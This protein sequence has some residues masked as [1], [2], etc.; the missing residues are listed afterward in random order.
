M[1]DIIIFAII[2]LLLAHRLY[3]VLGTTEEST[4]KKKSAEIIDLDKSQ[5]EET[6]KEQE[7]DSINDL[8][9][10]IISE[11]SKESQ[12]SINEIKELDESFSIY[13]FSKGA[14]KAFEIIISSFSNGDKK[15]LFNLCT[16]EVA[17]NFYQEYEKKHK[18]GQKINVNIVGI[19]SC[20]VKQVKKEN[21]L[22]T[23]KVKILSEQITTITD[24]SNKVVSGDIKHIDEIND[25]WFFTRDFKQSSPIW[26]LAKATN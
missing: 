15:S 20:A 18:L 17:E 24:K 13:K 14:E 10:D 3:S 11:L 1:I 19:E 26:K 8:D 5:Y 12:S 9:D 2:A 16:T 22:V 4:T 25:N 6:K 21:S 23:I 7:A